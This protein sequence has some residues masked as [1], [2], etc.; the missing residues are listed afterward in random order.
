MTDRAP[1][2]LTL[3]TK[4][5]GRIHVRPVTEAECGAPATFLPEPDR[6]R[7]TQALGLARFRGA[8]GTRLLFTRDDGSLLWLVGMGPQADTR[9][10]RR[11]VAG[12]TGELAECQPWSVLLPALPDAPPGA[13]IAAAAEGAVL[14]AYRFSRKQEPPRHPGPCTL[15]ADPVGAEERHAL[16]RALAGCEGVLLTRDLVNTPAADL[17]PRELADAAHEVARRHG[18]HVRT[19]QGGEIREQGFHLLA[20]VGQA[21]ARPPTFT[22][23]RLGPAEARPHLALVGKGV[24][25]DSG[26]LD[27]KPAAAMLLMRKDMGGAATVLGVMDVLGRRGVSAPVMA[28]LPAAENCI[29]PEA[30]RPGD[31]LRS[32][33][34]RTVEVG[35]TDAESRLLLADGISYALAPRPERLLDLATLTG[36]A[37]V[38]LGPDVPA[39]FSTDEWFQDVLLGAARRADEHLWPMPLV[40]DYDSWLDSSFAD[41]N[42]VSA[43]SRAGAITAALFLRRFVGECP[44]SH[45]DLYGWEDKGRPEAPKGGN[46]SMVRTV[47]AAVEEVLAAR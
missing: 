6:G 36:A 38:A 5:A 28:V 47:A 22:V 2:T 41:L 33:S 35:N 24:V 40:D 42:H 30:Y 31:I 26:G 29:G 19:F 34:G 44:W 20:A 17:G 9:A 7:L 11:A 16:A 46:G 25:F 12:I 37:R 15:V 21:S 39:L 14:S 10:L 45:V 43:D 32:H 1:L 23:L 27:L 4:P 8:A 13:A 18:M 3:A